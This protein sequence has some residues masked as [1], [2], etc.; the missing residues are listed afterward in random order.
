[1][2]LIYFSTLAAV[3]IACQGPPGPSGEPGA[4]G[5]QGVQGEQGTAGPQG[6]P[7]PAGTDAQFPTG[8]VIAFAGDTAPEGWQLCDGSALSRTAEAGLFGVIEIKYG[9]GDGVTTFNVPDLR[10]RTAVG[11]GQGSGLTNR[12]L[13]D[14]F[15]SE[16]HQLSA[17]NLPPHSHS[18]TTASGNPM[19]YRVVD[20]AGPDYLPNHDTGWTGGSTYTEANDA[21]WPMA[22]HTHNFTTDNGPGFS[23]AINHMQPSLVMN[24]IIKK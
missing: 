15:G 16:L 9:G 22:E 10:G 24:Y 7:G 13:G 4:P 11:A 1:M 14:R 8:S 12:A 5:G 20:Q 19:I 2:R 3:V 18:G 6:S 17:A 21:A 23:A